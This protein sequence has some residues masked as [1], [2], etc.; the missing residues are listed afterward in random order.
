[1]GMVRARERGQYQATA[2]G[3]SQ[4]VTQALLP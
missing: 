2:T 4:A 1:M 3:R